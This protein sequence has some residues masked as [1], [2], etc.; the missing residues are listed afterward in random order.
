MDTAVARGPMMRQRIG[1]SIS[2]TTT[3][4]SAAFGFAGSS[5]AQIGFHFELA[6]TAATIAAAARVD[7]RMGRV[8]RYNFHRVSAGP[9]EHLNAT[10]A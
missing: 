1:L 2:S 10:T 3:T 8:A 7:R 5:S 9:V 6:S 4:I